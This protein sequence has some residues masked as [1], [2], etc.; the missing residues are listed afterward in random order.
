MLHVVA[1][2]DELCH[3]YVCKRH[4]TCDSRYCLKVSVS[5]V[6]VSWHPHMHVGSAS[7][8]RHRIA[9]QAHVFLV[10][11]TFPAEVSSLRPF[12]RSHSPTH[13]QNT[14]QLECWTAVSL[15]LSFSL[16]LSL[17]RSLSLSLSFSLQSFSLSLS[18]RARS[19]SLRGFPYHLLSR[20]LSLLLSLSL[21]VPLSLSHTTC[22]SVKVLDWC[23][24]LSVSPSLSLLFSLL[25]SLYLCLSLLLP[26]SLALASTRKHGPITV[27]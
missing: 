24:L 10:L 22:I 23:L 1:R 19:L 14:C 2:I 17:S 18:L 20:S 8:P 15:S 27:S 4:V 11:A 7:S 25:F 26:F 9:W 21:S 13:T 3:T 16:S 12:T 6:A 5:Q